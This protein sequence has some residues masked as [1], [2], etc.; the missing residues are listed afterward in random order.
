MKERKVGEVFIARKD[1]PDFVCNDA[2]LLRLVWILSEVVC[3]VV[4]FKFILLTIFNASRQHQRS[5]TKHIK[6][7]DDFFYFT[8]IQFAIE[9]NLF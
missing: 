5:V 6:I 4:F 2:E 7:Y 9:P 3:L 8:Q 1:A